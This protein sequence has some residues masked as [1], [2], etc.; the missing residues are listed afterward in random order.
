LSL[1]LPSLVNLSDKLIFLLKYKNE[2]NTCSATLTA[3]E[4]EV[5]PSAMLLLVKNS[6]STLS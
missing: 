3:F 6:R 4:V 2:V 1:N 5:I